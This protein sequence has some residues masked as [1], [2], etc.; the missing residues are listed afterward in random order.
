MAAVFSISE[1][2]GTVFYRIATSL[3]RLGRDRRGA[4]LAMAAL[5]VTVLIRLAG[6]ATDIASWEISVRDMPGAAGHAGFSGAAAA[7]E[8]LQPSRFTGIFIRQPRMAMV[9]AV[10][11]KGSSNNSCVIALAENGKLSVGSGNLN[12]AVGV[13]LSGCDL[14]N[15]SRDLQSTELVGGASLNARNIFLA[16][17]Y[18]LSAGAIMTASRYLTTY[19]S[20]VAD[21]YAGLRVPAYSGCTRNRY[22]LDAGKTETISPGVYCGG[23]D[24]AGGATL[25]LAPGTYI[26]DDG[27]FEVS[28]N[29]TLNGADVTI[30]LTSHTASHYGA[31]DFHRGSTIMISAPVKEATAGTPGV[32][33]WV[34]ER[35]P[36]SSDMFNGGNTQNINGAIYLPSQDVKFSGGSSAGTRCSQLVALAVTFT[37]NSYFRHDCVGAGISDPSPP[38]LLVE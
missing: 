25:K 27:D 20:P 13:S 11:L 16:G 4:P 8:V 32:A 22:K 18:A 21:P 29:S 38:P 3:R 19:T 35:A 10:P 5:G 31:I 6:L 17:G 26:L 34:D 30:F 28:G 12:R 33:I 2:S 15:D 24:V 36:T 7:R 1:R 14:Y 23:I 37:G 9:Q